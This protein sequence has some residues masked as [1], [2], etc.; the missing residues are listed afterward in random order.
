MTNINKFSFTIAKPVKNI[1]V[2]ISLSGTSLSMIP[3]SNAQSSSPLQKHTLNTQTAKEKSAVFFHT[4]ISH[5]NEYPDTSSSTRSQESIFQAFHAKSNPFSQ[6]DGSLIQILPDNE[7]DKN[8]LIKT[9][10]NSPQNTNPIVNKSNSYIYAQAPETNTP[11]PDKSQYNL[12]NPTP[13]RLWRD[14][15]TGRPDKTE[16]PFTIDAGRFSMEADLFV[17]TQSVDRANDTFTESYNYVIPTFKIGLTNNIDLQIVPELFNT[18]R[19]KVGTQPSQTISGYGD[20]TVRLKVNL[21][22][23]DGGKT[24]FGV[25]PFIKFPTSQNGIGNSSIEG[26]VIFPF[27][28]SLSEKWDLGL[29][30]EFDLNRNNSDTGYNIGFVNSLSLGYKISDRWSTYFEFYTNTGAERGFAATFDTGIKYL[31]TENIQLDAGVNVGL[32]EA[33]DSFQPFVGMSIRF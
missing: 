28:I 33:A 6:V 17:Y 5:S 21:W 30:T 24:A 18:V 20:T 12:F 26:G 22:G 29:Q 4:K 9:N 14:F 23:N 13:P 19:T 11:T 16:N 31:L 27:A 2:A 7:N 10:S 25:V 32:T 8:K 1:L 3:H 15:S